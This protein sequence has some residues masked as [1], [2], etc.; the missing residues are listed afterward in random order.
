MLLLLLLLLLSS[1]Y[2][3]FLAGGECVIGGKGKEEG[4]FATVRTTGVTMAWALKIGFVTGRPGGG[5]GV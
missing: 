2:G 4:A 5:E 3:W 1:R